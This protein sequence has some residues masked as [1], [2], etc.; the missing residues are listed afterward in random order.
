MISTKNQDG[1]RQKGIAINKKISFID[2]IVV[3]LWF[4]LSC[5]ICRGFFYPD[6][7]LI[8]RYK[9][10]GSFMLF[11]WGIR[12]GVPVIFTGLLV[13]YILL[14]TGRL[15][16][17]DAAL[18]VGSVV[19]SVLLLYPVGNFI[20]SKKGG[21]KSVLNDYHPYLQ[22]MP[23]VP[24]H[25]RE[26][27][28]AKS[29]LTL[30][31]LGGSTTE[32]TD[33]KGKDWVGRVENLLRLRSG[34]SELYC[35]NLGRQWYTTLH[36][37]INYETN[38]RHHNPDIIIVMHA[39]NDLLHN[40]DESYYSHGRFREDYG[41][42]YGPMNRIV[43]PRGFYAE[44]VSNLRIWYQK[45]RKTLELYEFPGIRSFNKNLNN[46][47]DLAQIDG[48]ITALMTQPTL[49]K[50]KMDS[51][52]CKVLQMVN[53]ETCGPRMIWSYTT[54]YRGMKTYNNMTRSIAAARGVYLIDLE[55][56]VPKTLTFIR[57]EV[58]YRDTTFSLI[59]EY[60][61]EQIIRQGIIDACL[62]NNKNHSEIAISKP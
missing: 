23:P 1:F 62:S 48:T 2:V 22:L 16:Y 46:L 50:E 8:D 31:F 11:I 40:A 27:P 13:I 42:F 49:L 28:E 3:L 25:D 26:K 21:L 10:F 6:Q 53:V 61:S 19:V 7:Y 41:H 20:Y 17:A 39:I 44:V 34:N 5:W 14:R 15:K 33:N 18:I 35:T 9:E 57:D 29:G 36:T 60:I 51:E 58:H 47:I 56:A 59:A 54:A 12:I 52:E 30:F 4:L 55:K 32:F 24:S 45:P 37:L 38:L 43:G